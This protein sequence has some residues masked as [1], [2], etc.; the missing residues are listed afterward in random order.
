MSSTERTVEVAFGR[1]RFHTP[2]KGV[3]PLQGEKRE[4]WMELCAQAATEQDPE[5]LME[6]VREINALL[7]EKEQRLGII[8]SGGKT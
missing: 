6:L 8:K 5:R 7:E 1:L 4:R 3:W 2:Q